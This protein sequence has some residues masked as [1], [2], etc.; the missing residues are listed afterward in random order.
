MDL[1]RGSN[2]RQGSLSKLAN[3][4]KLLLLVV[5]TSFTINLLKQPLNTYAASAPAITSITPNSGY[6][7][8]GDI[9]TIIGS[10]FS[11]DAK[12]TFNGIAATVQSVSSDGTTITATTPSV[13]VAGNTEVRVTN[14]NG[15]FARTFFA[16]KASAPTITAVTPNSGPA[17]GG[18]SVT[19]TGDNLYQNLQF[20]KLSNGENADHTCGISAS[21]VYCWGNN[22]NGQ[23]GN[24][25]TTN[26]YLPAAV[27]TAGTPMDDKNMIDVAVAGDFTAALASDGTVYT[28]GYNDYGQLGNNTTTSS[29]VPVAVTTTGAL[30]G[31]TVTQI[32]V[33]YD[34]SVALASDGTVYTWGH[35]GNDQ[36]GNNT[37]ANSSV[38]VAVTITGALAGKTITQVAAG[39]NFAVALASDGTVYTWGLNNNGQL[40]NNTTANSSVPVAVTTTGVLNNKVITQIA[41]G[42][43]HMVAVDSDGTVYAWGYNAQGQLGNNTTTNSTVPIAVIASGALLGKTVTQVAAGGSHTAALSS[44]GRVYAWGYNGYGQLGNNTTTNSSVPVAA[45]T[46]GVLVGKTVT[47]VAAGSNHTVA[48]TSDGSTYGWGRNSYYQLG[49]SNNTSNFSSPISMNNI[50]PLVSSISF[51]NIKA[52]ISSNNINKIIVVT[53]AH[54]AGAADI[55]LSGNYID[56]ATVANGFTYVKSD[57]SISSISPTSGSVKGNDIVTINGSNFAHDVQLSNISY[58]SGSNN[59]SCGLYLGSVYCWGYNNYGQLG[60]GTT[61]SRTVPTPVATANTPMSRKTITQVSV[62]ANHTLALASDGTVY[63]WGYNHYGQLGDNT[64]SNRLLPVEISNNGTVI[65]QIAAGGDYSLSVDASGYLYQWGNVLTDEAVLDFYSYSNTCN[66]YSLPTGAIGLSFNMTLTTAYDNT[67]YSYVYDSSGAQ[68]AYKTASYTPYYGTQTYSNIASTNPTSSIRLCA[69]SSSSN[70]WAET[71]LT[72][73]YTYI[74]KPVKIN[75]NG[76][77]S[78]VA[79]SGDHTVALTSDGRVYSWGTNS[80]GQLGNNYTNNSNT[81][82]TISLGALAGKTVTQIAAG[83][84]HTAALASDGTVYTWGLNNYGQLGNNTTANSLVPAAVTTTGALAGK[85]VTQIAAGSN[86]TAA[87]ASDGT[88]Y[89]WGYNGN[90]QLGNNTTTNSSVPVAATTTG[91]LSG[92]TVTQVAAGN[93]YVLALA[94][95]NTLSAWGNNSNG[96]LST[97]NATSSTVPVASFLNNVPVDLNVTFGGNAAAIVS[98]MSSTQIKA[99]TPAHGTGTVGVNV[100]SANNGSATLPDAYTYLGSSPAITSITPNSG[101]NAGGDIVTIIGSSF[102]SDAKVTFNGIAA[103]VQSVSSDGTTITATT[104]SVTVAGN[105]EVRVTNSNGEFARTFFAYK[106]SAPTITAVTPNSGPASGG[107]SVTLTGDNLYQ[108]LQFAKLSNGENADHTC[109]I[110]ASKVYCW[111]NNN[112]GQLGN[113]STTNSYLPAAVSTA[114]TPMDDKNMIDVAVAGDFT[115]ALASDGTVYTWGYNDYGQL[116]NNTTTSSTVPVAVTT[117]GALSGKTVTQI[118]VG[119]DCSVAL[120]SDGTVYTWGHN[121][122]DQLGNNTTAN[123]SVP[124]AVTITGALAGK[125]ITQVAAGGNF[126]VAL[127]SDGTVYTWGLNNNGQLGNNT[128]A[129]SSVPVAVTTTGVLNNKVITQIAAGSQHMVAVDSD[130]TVY[131]WGYNAQGQLGNNTTTNSTVPIAVIAS[132]ALLGKTVTQVAAGGS[133]TAAL[134]SDGRVYAWGYNGYGQLGNNTTTNSSVPVAA[135]TTGVLVGKTVTQVAAGSNH[136]VALTSDGSTYGWGYNNQGQLG[137]NSIINSN[138]PTGCQTITYSNIYFGEQTLDGMNY[139]GSNKISGKPKSYVPGGYVDVKVIDANNQSAILT[140]GYRYIKPIVDNIQPASG[141]V[142][143]G[144]TVVVTGNGLF[145]NDTVTINGANATVVSAA[146]DGTSLTITTPVNLAGTYDIVVTDQFNQ[147]VT[148]AKSFTYKNLPPTATSITP[149]LGPASGN[150]TVTVNGSNLITKGGFSKIARGLEANHACGIVIGRVYCWGSNSGQLGDG[151]TANRLIPTPVKTTDTPMD[152]KTINSVAVGGNFTIALDSNGIVYSW[153]VNSYGRLGN[154]STTSSKV[155]VA[156]DTTGVLKGKTITAISAGGDHALALDSNGVVYAWGNNTYGQLGN[157]STSYS[158]VPV[159]VDTSGV[160][161][162]KT[163]TAISAGEYHNL[164]LDSDGVAYSWGYNGYAQLGNNST[165]N[166]LVPVT[167]DTTNIANN[168]LIKFV[169]AGWARSFVITSDGLGYD[170]G[171]SGWGQL[172]NGSTAEVSKLT[173]ISMNGAL[174]NKTLV[175]IIAGG[176]HTIAL[177]SDGTVYGWGNNANGE[178]GDGTTTNRLVPTAVITSGVLS[179]KVIIAISAGAGHSSAL[180]LDGSMYAWGYNGGGQIGNNSTTSSPVPVKVAK[181]GLYGAPSVSLGGSN[182]T[183]VSVSSD[184]TTITGTT[185]PHAAGTVDT[186]ITNPDGQSTTLANSYTYVA[187]PTITS[188]TP[189]SGLTTG[190]DSAIIYGTNF[191]NK[192]VVKFDGVAASIDYISPTEILVTA[193]PAHVSPGMVDVT[194]TDQYNQVSTL[195]NGFTYMLPPITLTGIKDSYDVMSGGKTITLTGTNF[196]SLT[197]KDG[198]SYYDAYF[199]EDGTGT[200]NTGSY[201]TGL[202]KGTNVKVI[203]ST[204]MTVTVPSH[205]VGLV[206]VTVSG[207]YTAPSLL[208]S[209]FSYYPDGYKYLT[210]TGDTNYSCTTDNINSANT[211]CSLMATEPGKF[212][213]EAISKDGSPVTLT[214]EPV[215]LNLTTNSTTGAFATSLTGE[216]AGWNKTSVSIP[217][218]SNK[219]TFYYKDSTPGTI[220]LTATDSI[221]GIKTTLSNILITSRFKI[222]VTGVTNPTNVGVPSSVTV[223]AVDYTGKA[224]SD[225]VGTISFTSTDKAAMLPSDYTFNL[226][227]HGRHTFTNGITFLT[228]GTWDVTATDKATSS[229]SGTQAGI[230]VGPAGKGTASKLSFIT[231]PQ[232]FSLDDTSSTMTVQVQDSDSNPVTVSTDT[233]VYLTS[234][235]SDNTTNTTGSYSLDNGATWISLASKTNNAVQAV[236]KAGTSSINFMYKDTVKGTFTLKVALTITGNFGYTPATQDV[237]VGV[238][239][240]A[241]L[242]LSA[243]TPNLVGSWIPVTVYLE[244]S[245]SDKVTSTNDVTLNLTTTNT[246]AELS[247]SPDGSNSVTSSLNP[248]IV[249]GSNSVTVYVRCTKLKDIPLVVADGRDLTSTDT[250][251]TGDNLTIVLTSS[252]TGIKLLPSSQTTK[253]H[254]S[255]PLTA[256]LTDSYGNAMGSDSDVILNF[257]SDSN[258][259]YYDI[260]SNGK[261]TNTSLTTKILASISNTTG[262]SSTQVFFNEFTIKPS[263]NLTVT[264]SILNSDGVT[265][266]LL[267]TDTATIASTAN[268]YNGRLKL[269]QL[270]PAVLT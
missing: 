25:S 194:V 60:D 211:S 11:S 171:D 115:A 29:T 208:T 52:T 235:S 105:T 238:G 270:I 232:S 191:N 175:S 137:D 162:G 7:A 240:P 214:N 116:G 224:Q 198:S 59:H 124:V 65:T 127:A 48:L 96:A 169:E 30:S 152:G 44:D 120:A 244:D 89:T 57:V 129:N 39:G 88:V 123:S 71:R 126:A 160:L 260:A 222:L 17:S 186:V 187:G 107:T 97:N 1:N 12:V 72:I 121:G 166:S 42:S 150:Q 109:G 178:L 245:A 229:I 146:S 43:Q 134:S 34:C 38:P 176:N 5:L 249:A 80:Y 149:T 9:V 99:I 81:P 153:G 159:A 19:L 85:T 33:G 84:N 73:N 202:V 258:D 46:T 189:T 83:S 36:L 63:S 103:T 177:T 253:V 90:G 3:L 117:T 147:S 64:M 119:Y 183:N 231:N 226:A 67:N 173:A 4:L 203:N 209:S 185:A 13:T 141:L 225:Y 32:A 35:N 257:T 50:T 27:S 15:E 111:G 212:T 168:K 51:G 250:A 201:P 24:N 94:S 237:T 78:Q 254:D 181:D 268:N 144:D 204:T 91:A 125:T 14:S 31:K 20:A 247:L 180:A 193:T 259:G 167:M 252:V 195:S 218:G 92:K 266:T 140:N 68:I 70:Y 118:A 113:N 216:T 47:Q 200:T 207:T 53:P 131:A 122:N 241:K 233:T 156:V 234:L 221:T 227:D 255:L 18:T 163:I 248:A 223:Q 251:L 239:K 75:T 101:Y 21:K 267:G 135:T 161:S 79:T 197:N 106:A 228:E 112:N 182:L 188:I 190:G 128:T 86:F 98:R 62:G 114:G 199:G 40:G 165:S 104:P 192:D 184:G 164:V 66:T 58:G 22:N 151:T 256:I 219:A 205:M 8:G 108:N 206:D 215:T 142:A 76:F 145:A 54:N 133:H 139:V 246:D 95:D 242:A 220:N 77:I 110:S 210:A 213:I 69:N 236:I 154:N 172:G 10:S 158:M 16:Y 155:P 130:G 87:L 179:G 28:W 26:S 217:V 6:N 136:T 132:G 56:T 23:L 263:I 45:T 49:N 170:C 102:S 265:T 74:S 61:T 2:N 93:D 41:A 148:L 261:F 143:G 37:T 82:T 243:I 196:S 262:T 55:S 174:N 157:S 264:A 138:V 230:V 269:Y 100:A